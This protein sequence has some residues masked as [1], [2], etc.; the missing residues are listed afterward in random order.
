MSFTPDH[1]SCR[2]CGKS[3]SWDECC[4][5]HDDTGFADC[6]VQVTG[7]L[8]LNGSLITREGECRVLVDPEIQRTG[9]ATTAQP[10]GD[11]E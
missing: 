3:I 4:W 10:V 6:G 1:V 5:T 11:W 7:G 8:P 9:A 2:S